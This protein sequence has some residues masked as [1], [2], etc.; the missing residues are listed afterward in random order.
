MN[1]SN[2]LILFSNS[3]YHEQHYYASAISSCLEQLSYNVTL[4]NTDLDISES[5]L[6]AAILQ[7]APDLIFTLGL[8][9]F[10]LQMLGD[11]LF[12]NG[13]YCPCVHLLTRHPAYDAEYLSQRMNFTMFFYSY[14]T[15]YATYIERFFKRVPSVAVLP[16]YQLPVTDIKSFEDRTIDLYY[17]SSY[18][19]SED[20]LSHIKA[21]P[22]VFANICLN[23]IQSMQDNTDTYLHKCLADYLDKIH[24]SLSDNEFNE[25]MQTMQLVELYVK[26]LSSEHYIALLL[27]NGYDVTVSGENWN[28]FLLKSHTNLHIIGEHGLNCYE[29]VD[30]M[31]NSKAILNL[32]FHKNSGIHPRIISALS[33]H[34]NCVTNENRQISEIIG[35]DNIFTFKTDEDFLHQTDLA[36]HHPFTDMSTPSLS[37]VLSDIINNI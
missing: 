12:L 17:P 29:A 34:A 21:L 2:I 6:Q 20:I 16:F 28:Q 37:D 33:S 3:P 26:S 11:D 35:F 13:A 24:F 15:E 23:V 19:P 10:H 30:T 4:I 22:E 7:L 5:A 1:A 31:C 25:I 18:I 8:S 32:Q 14:F 9:G 27:E 36:I